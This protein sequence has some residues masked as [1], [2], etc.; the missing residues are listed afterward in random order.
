MAAMRELRQAAP[1]IMSAASRPT[2]QQLLA[3]T[4]IQAA[5][6]SCRKGARIGIMWHKVTNE[7]MLFKY[8][9][10]NCHFVDKKTKEDYGTKLVGHLE[11]VDE[12]GELMACSK[13]VFPDVDLVMI[14][15]SAK[16]DG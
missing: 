3:A 12:S 9:S 4:A 8:C 6:R 13:I 14:E 16:S 5:W 10:T 15:E 1:E 2:V 7:K 11:H